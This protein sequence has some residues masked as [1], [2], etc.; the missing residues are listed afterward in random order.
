MKVWTSFENIAA[1]VTRQIS[2]GNDMH[3]QQLSLSLLQWYE[4]TDCATTEEQFAIE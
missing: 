3:S 2:V 1:G 4:R